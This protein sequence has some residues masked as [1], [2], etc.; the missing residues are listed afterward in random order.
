MSGNGL[1]GVTAVNGP[2]FSGNGA[3]SDDRC[4]GL[5]LCPKQTNESLA[6]GVRK[7]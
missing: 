4:S 2:V 3:L 7:G 5:R 1:E 6:V